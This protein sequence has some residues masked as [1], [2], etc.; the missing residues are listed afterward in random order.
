MCTA[1][2]SETMHRYRY[3]WIRIVPALVVLIALTTTT[4]GCIDIFA[5]REYLIPEKDTSVEYRQIEKVAL[6]H[7]Y[8]SQLSLLQPLE[9]YQTQHE[10]NI[11]DNTKLLELDIELEMIRGDQLPEEVK[12]ALEQL[13]DLIPQLGNASEY[14]DSLKRHVWVTLSKPDGSLWKELRFNSS[15][16]HI[17]RIFSPQTGVWTMTI[18]SKGFGSED[19]YQDVLEV[20]VNANE[21]QY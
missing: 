17:E 12:E 6:Q 14:L 13:K 18:E 11:V 21:P 3:R 1:L 2:E 9:E 16:K 10:I 20:V 15:A 8:T 19:I 4:S 7:H 5:A